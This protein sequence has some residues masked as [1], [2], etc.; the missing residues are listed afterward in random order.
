MRRIWSIVSGNSLPSLALRAEIGAFNLRAQPGSRISPEPVRAC[1]REP[2]ELARL[3]HR[4]SGEEVQLDEL[5]RGG[6][7]GGKSAQC[8]VEPYQVIGLFVQR[9]ARIEVHALPVT[10][11]LGSVFAT[12]AVDKDTAHGLG[13][14]RE[15]VTA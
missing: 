5:G 3:L 9:D 15:E 13:R 12:G 14:C 6:I 8:L 1:P 4:K 2:E 10:A 7:L 11:V